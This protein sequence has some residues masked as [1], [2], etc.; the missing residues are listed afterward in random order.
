LLDR[1]HRRGIRRRRH[2]C[3]SP[4]RGRTAGRRRRPHDPVPPHRSCTRRG[5]CRRCG[6]QLA[7]EVFAVVPTIGATVG[8]TVLGARA[9]RSSVRRPRS[10]GTPTALASASPASQSP[11]TAHR[12]VA[13]RDQLRT[14]S[15]ASARRC[16]SSD[17]DP[18]GGTGNQADAR[19]MPRAFARS[20]WSPSHW[21]PRRM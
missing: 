2:Q 5:R 19:Y 6:R 3:A 1:R 8:A 17:D 20:P 12:R 15:V 4:I 18:A 13:A 11:N 14:A 21:R 16:R 9:C 7:T 10:T